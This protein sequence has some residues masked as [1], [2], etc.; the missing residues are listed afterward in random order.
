LKAAVIDIGTNSCRLLIGEKNSEQSFDI[1]A[2]RLE[3][4]RLG[5][6]VDQSRKLKEAAVDRVVQALKK[7]KV[8]IEEYQVPKTRVIGTSALRDVT[9]SN[10]LK[11]KLN[12]LGFELEIISGK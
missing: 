1:L 10:L 12:K 3:I 6:G 4:T 11:S 8:I 7:Y 2:R 9:N 5:E